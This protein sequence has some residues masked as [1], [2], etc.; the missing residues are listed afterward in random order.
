MSGARRRARRSSA[1]V[2][3]AVV[4]LVAACA[5]ADRTE[6]VPAGQSDSGGGAPSATVVDP[7]HAVASP[8]PL[9]TRL[10]GD[11]LLVV[12][13]HTLDPALVKR[14]KAVRVGSR[15]GVTA[16]EP[17]SFAQFAVENKTYNIAAI[18]PSTYRAFT[19]QS[20][21]AWQEQW[22]RVAGGEIAVRAG[23]RK[24]LPLDEAGYLAVGS[25]DTTHRIHVGAYS[26]SAVGVVD[27]MV[28]RSWGEELGM[29]EANALLINTGLASPQKV[30]AKIE[31]LAD[32]SITAL[33]IVAQSGIDPDTYQ[34]VIPVGSFRDAIGIYRYTPI[35]GGRV[36]PEQSWV[37]SHIT[38]ELMPIIGSMTCNKAMMPQLRAA[39]IE[40]Q[41]SGL[42]DEI[43]PGEYAGCYYPRFI[44]GSTK[45]SNHSFG[46]AFDI[47]VPGN[48]RGVPG[49]IDRGVV[50][51]FKR[52]GFA[53]GGDWSYT[54]PMHFELS[55]I[56]KPG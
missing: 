20:S 49:E 53:W 42:A 47:N 40:I 12:S 22:D 19:G 14:I 52:W 5:P 21:A 7:A 26:P 29:P 48:Q 1:V 56:V 13:D 24:K 36:Q 43:H 3:A 16:A 44:A 8:G 9:T 34:T 11:D 28:N 6:A 30:R 45:L 23:L 55:R 10:Y 38:T 50:A 31:K 4:L 32:L 25:G 17:F 46:L 54:D 39:L 33:D 15:K 51:I 18:D 27:A 37:S 35:G 41:Q 2:A